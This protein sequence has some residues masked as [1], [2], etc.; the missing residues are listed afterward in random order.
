MALANWQAMAQGG[1]AAN[2]IQNSVREFG[3]LQTLLEGMP[4][5]KNIAFGFGT[6]E[7]GYTGSSYEGL[8][9]AGVLDVVKN[10][11]T[12][13][14]GA[15][16]DH[17]QVK[18]GAYGLARGE[19]PAGRDTLL[20]VLHAGRIGRAGLRGVV[21]ERGPREDLASRILDAVQRS[22]LLAY[23]RQSRRVSG[24]D[25]QPDDAALGRLVGK[26]EAAGRR[27]EAL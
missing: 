7:T 8:W 10:G 11:A 3:L 17:I 23:H 21:G 19:T 9:V 4:A 12:P 15:D 13:R 26:Y 2:A 25:Y 20:L 6:I 24:F 5:E 14:Y 27:R 16:A 1:F 18:R 22:D